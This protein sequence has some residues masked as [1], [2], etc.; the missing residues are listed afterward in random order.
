M[1]SFLYTFRS[2]KNLYYG[3]KNGHLYI[4]QVLIE[5]RRFDEIKLAVLES[6][7]QKAPENNADTILLVLITTY[8]FSKY[9]ANKHI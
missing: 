8:R 2:T 4:T 7:I 9:V 6:I 3:L 5:S 1:N